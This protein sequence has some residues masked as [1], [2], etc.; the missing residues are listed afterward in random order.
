MFTPPAL[1]P[2]GIAFNYDT[3]MRLFLLKWLDAS[4]LFIMNK[5]SFMLLIS[6]VS[7]RFFEELAV[8]R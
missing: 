1:A 8:R 5:K 2:K 4:V 6:R 7:D 3:N